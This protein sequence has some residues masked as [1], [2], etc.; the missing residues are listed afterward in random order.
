MRAR[1]TRTVEAPAARVWGLVADP[2]S[3]PRW[4]PRTQRVE[5]V[6]AGGWTS[7]MTTDRG[8][9]VRADYRLVTSEA[10]RRRRWAQQLEGSPF[11]RLLESHEVEVSLEPSGGATAVTIEIEQRLRGWARLAPFL[12]RRAARRQAAEA[13]DGIERAV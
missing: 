6:G 5:G 12:I 9:T 11:E 13:L 10:P 2:W 3:L 8:R 1:R 7:V 4:W